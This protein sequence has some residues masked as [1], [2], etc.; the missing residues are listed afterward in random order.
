M[1]REQMAERQML[2]SD[3]SDPSPFRFFRLHLAQQKG[4]FFEGDSIWSLLLL[5]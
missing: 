2:A 5:L 4:F 3:P 1:E